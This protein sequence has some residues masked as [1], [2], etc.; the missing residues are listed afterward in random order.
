MEYADPLTIETI[1]D[2]KIKEEK[3]YTI[4]SNKK[5]I[6]NLVIKNCFSFIKFYANL[7][8]KNLI[9]KN[10]ENIYCLEE[11]KANKFLSIC[12]SIDEVYQQIESKLQN[13]NLTE[14][15]KKFFES[16]KDYEDFLDSSGFPFD[17]YWYNEDT[18][19]MGYTYMKEFEKD[20]LILIKQEK[21]IKPRNF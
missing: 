10:Y 16:I 9:E 15:Q 4:E 7:N 5:N 20:S 14:I 3:S 21:R 19:A 12:D 13:Q 11:L 18:L 6:F 8:Q 2:L 1:Q 17:V